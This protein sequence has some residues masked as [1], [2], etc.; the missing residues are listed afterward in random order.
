[1]LLSVGL[2]K[3]AALSASTGLEAELG[4][5]A[6]RFARRLR[7]SCG[8]SGHLR[9]PGERCPRA[10][11]TVKQRPVTFG[12]PWTLGTCER[13]GSGE[14]A[15]PVSTFSNYAAIAGFG[16]R[17]CDDGDPGHDRS[18]R[19]GS[20]RADEAPRSWR[21]VCGVRPLY[22]RGAVDAAVP[23]CEEVRVAR[24]TA[25]CRAAVPPRSDR[26]GMRRVLLPFG[27]LCPHRGS[28]FP[29]VGSDPNSPCLRSRS[30]PRCASL[31][32]FSGDQPCWA[33]ISSRSPST[34]RREPTTIR[35]SAVRRRA[36]RSTPA[37]SSRAKTV[38]SSD[39]PAAR[40]W[41]P[42][43]ASRSICVE[44]A[45]SSSARRG[46]LPLSARCWSATRERNRWSN[47]LAM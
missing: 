36:A 13:V 42:S 43:G 5:S 14:P 44:S 21:A 33:Q 7:H 45:R 12:R 25:V 16:V 19:N 37:S 46:L 1:M 22:F 10:A 11:V 6:A 2:C 3:C 23:H 8:G 15:Q 35:S 41:S 9:C 24:R 30:R 20:A 32:Y 4:A 17:P 29:P 28:P 18:E 27:G 40:C 26:R 38:S 39:V 47:E 34:P 31:R